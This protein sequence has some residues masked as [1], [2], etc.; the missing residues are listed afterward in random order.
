MEITVLG[1]GCGVPSLKH[2]SPGFQIKINREVLIFDFGP[3]ILN[4]LEK[5]ETDYRV[6]S[7]I[8]FTHTHPDHTADLV[9]LI[10]ALKITPDFERTEPL[11]VHGPAGMANFLEL[12]SKTY[13]DWII[14]PGFKIMVKEL[15]RHEISFPDFMITTRPMR[16]SQASIGYRIEDKN[17]NSVV[18]SGDTDTNPEIKELARDANILILEC[19]FPSVRKVSGHLTPPEACQIAAEA[20]C[21]HL[22]LNHLY[23]PIEELKKEI[24]Q[25]CPKI[26]NGKITVA[27]DFIKFKL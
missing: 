23:P 1:S 8:F 2:G 12:L 14:D 3:G 24:N 25:V 27:S 20:N 5:V 21:E 9:P 11:T 26:Y 19:S 22:V 15:E 10:Q 7:N 6:L 18:Y 13:G 4:K 16:H 17:G